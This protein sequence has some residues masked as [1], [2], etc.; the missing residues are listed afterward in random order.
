MRLTGFEAITFAEREGL[1]LN[2]LEDAIDEPQ[3]G[4]SVAEAEAI[5]VDSP[6]LIYLDITEDE[7][8]RPRNM[9]PER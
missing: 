2:K 8:E 7:Y 6:E 1:T 4:L 5:A 3:Q 9:L